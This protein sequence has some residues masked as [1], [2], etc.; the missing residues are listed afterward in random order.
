MQYRLAT[1]IVP[2]ILPVFSKFFEKAIYN[3]MINFI[4]KH[5]ILFHHQYGFN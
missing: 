1:G 5:D 3:R 2:N 4:N